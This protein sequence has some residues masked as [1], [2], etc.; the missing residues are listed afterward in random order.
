[1]NPD[2]RQPKGT[3]KSM[4]TSQASGATVLCTGD[5]IYIL[6]K[7]PRGMFLT[8]TQGSKELLRQPVLRPW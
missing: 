1:M 5:V 7:T 2:D 4:K 6:A 3:K 8:V